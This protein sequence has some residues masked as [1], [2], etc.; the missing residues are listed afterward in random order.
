MSTL[1]LR[2]DVPPTREVVSSSLE[3]SLRPFFPSLRIGTSSVVHLL[4][5]NRLPLGFVCTHTSRGRRDLPRSPTP[6]SPK[7]RSTKRVRNDPTGDVLEGHSLSQVIFGGSGRETKGPRVEKVLTETHGIPTPVR[8]LV[9]TE[10]GR[11]SERRPPGDL[12]SQTTQRS[13]RYKGRGSMSFPGPDY[14]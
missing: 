2:T 12:R 5:D 10:T 11:P 6:G 7:Y 1:Y 4:P 14:G 13:G 8:T 9:D 3:P